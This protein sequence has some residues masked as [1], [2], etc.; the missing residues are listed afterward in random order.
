MTQGSRGARV[1]HT[2]QSYRIGLETFLTWAGPAGVSLLRPSANAGFRYARHLKSTGL[3][4]GSVSVRLAVGKALYASLRWAGSTDA[5][6]FADVK[7]ASDPVP[8]WEKGK[9]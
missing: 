1:S 7:A 3:A 9:P 2:L 8:R 6:P 5:A 4:P